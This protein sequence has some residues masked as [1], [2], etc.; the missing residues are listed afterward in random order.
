[1][2]VSDGDV[3]MGDAGRWITTYPKSVTG[4]CE[5]AV[6]IGTLGMINRAPTLQTI[7]TNASY[8]AYLEPERYQVGSN[9]F[10]GGP[11]ATIKTVNTATRDLTLADPVSVAGTITSINGH[12]GIWYIISADLDALDVVPVGT[13]FR[14]GSYIGHVAAYDDDTNSIRVLGDLSMVTDGSAFVLG[15]DEGCDDCPSTESLVVLQDRDECEP[16]RATYTGV[17]DGSTGGYIITIDDDLIEAMADQD[18][19]GGQVYVAGAFVG[20]I[21]QHDNPVSPGDPA[22]IYLNEATNVAMPAGSLITIYLDSGC[23]S[24]DPNVETL[25]AFVLAPE[26]V[27]L[28]DDDTFLIG[29]RSKTGATTSVSMETGFP[30]PT[31]YV[32]EDTGNSSDMLIAMEGQTEDTGGETVW[33]DLKFES[34]QVPGVFVTV[35]I[36]YNYDTP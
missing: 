26:N 29:F 5:R 14:V 18:L 25:F 30:A 7:F 13:Q 2:P 12:G 3:M 20:F 35:R 21:V 10:K 28:T 27:P 24:D 36:P 34:D 32:A 17:V 8:R 22:T 9:W 19:L 11:P 31:G 6:Q 1:M 15:I 16:V 23:E 4:L 33:V